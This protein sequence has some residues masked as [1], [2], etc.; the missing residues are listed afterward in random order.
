ML[1]KLNN[2]VDYSDKDTEGLIWQ[3]KTRLVQKDPMTC[4]RYFDY[5]VQEF[6]NTIL[7]SDCE[8]V[9]KLRYFFYRVQFEQRGSPHIHMLVWIENAPTLEKTRR[10]KWSN[11]LISTSL[12]VLLLKTL[13]SSC[14]TPDT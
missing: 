6:L 9:G 13:R 8:P 2:G 5:R 1:A 14:G 11:L 7:K 3:E 4:S 10:K 12:V